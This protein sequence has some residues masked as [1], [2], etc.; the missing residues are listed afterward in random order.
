M[1]LD[2]GV[3]VPP[4]SSRGTD[5]IQTLASTYLRLFALFIEFVLLPPPSI[6]GCGNGYHLGYQ[7]PKSDMSYR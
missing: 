4:I 6:G 5:I 2:G 1:A 7:H 3:K